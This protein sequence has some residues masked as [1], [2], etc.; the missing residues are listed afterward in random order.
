MYAHP[1]PYPSPASCFIT[2]TV[3]GES[4]SATPSSAQAP[5]VLSE[6]GDLQGGTSERWEGPQRGRGRAWGTPRESGLRDAV[7]QQGGSG[8][9]EERQERVVANTGTVGREMQKREGRR[10]R[11]LCQFN[12]L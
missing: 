2:E 7:A 4:P 9:S 1:S 6:G 10:P 5:M 11:G 8:K 3:F 12:V